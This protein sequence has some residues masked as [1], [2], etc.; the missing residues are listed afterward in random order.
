MF[1]EDGNAGFHD[2]VL[3]PADEQQM[4]HIVSAHDHQ[5]P[6]GIKCKAVDNAQSAV[7]AARDITRSIEQELEQPHH[8]NN[9]HDHDAQGEEYIEPAVA[10]P[11]E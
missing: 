5:V 11:A 3:R 4:L 9:E 2:H 10:G 1:V 7:A 6:F 8:E